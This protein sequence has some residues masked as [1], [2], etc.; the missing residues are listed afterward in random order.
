MKKNRKLV[1]LVHLWEGGAHMHMDTRASVS[2]FQNLG[3]NWEQMHFHIT[4][5]NGGKVR[6]IREN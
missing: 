1:Y 2:L 4:T 3:N 6:G 5:Q